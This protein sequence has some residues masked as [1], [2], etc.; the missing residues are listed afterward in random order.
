[1][2]DYNFCDRDYCA[3]EYGLTQDETDPE[4]YWC[5]DCGYEV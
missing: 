5:N 3:R 4:V 2:S 1:M